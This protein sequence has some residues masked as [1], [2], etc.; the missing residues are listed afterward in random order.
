MLD[1]TSALF[2]GGA[3]D[4]G[5]QVFEFGGFDWLGLLSV[6]DHHGLANFLEFERTLH[7]LGLVGLFHFSGRL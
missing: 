5:A 1:E 3:L 7:L 2:L 4:G 6:E